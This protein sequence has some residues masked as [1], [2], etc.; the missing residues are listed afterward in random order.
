MQYS[1]EILRTELHRLRELVRK[2]EADE[3]IC[4]SAIPHEGIKSK[5]LDIESAIAILVVK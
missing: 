4:H 2:I 5:I 1:I 3:Y